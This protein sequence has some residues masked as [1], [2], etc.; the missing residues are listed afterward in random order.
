MV[1]VSWDKCCS[2]KGEGGIG[3]KSAK[4]WNKALLV[5]HIP[6]KKDTSGLESHSLMSVGGKCAAVLGRLLTK[7]RL[8]HMGGSQDLTWFLCNSS[9]EDHGH[10]FFACHFSNR[11]VLL[12]QHKLNIYFDPRELAEW[13]TRGRRFSILIRKVTCAC[14]VLLVYMIWQVRN[15]ARVNFEVPHPRVIVTQAIKDII[16]KFW[17]RHKAALTNLDERWIGKLTAM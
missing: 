2:S 14:H 9:N 10:L 6:L 12:L 8:A 16:S 5:L 13:N 7:D 1:Y 11:C 4:T 15:G 17:A 3:I